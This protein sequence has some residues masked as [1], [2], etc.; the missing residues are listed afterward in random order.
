MPLSLGGSD[1]IVD[2]SSTFK[3]PN[4]VAGVGDSQSFQI[5]KS[6]GR[7]K[8]PRGKKNGGDKHGRVAASEKGKRKNRIFQ[9]NNFFYF[10]IFFIFFKLVTCYCSHI[11]IRSVAAIRLWQKEGV[12]CPLITC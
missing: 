2:G 10:F 9:N 6:T 3:A 1:D 12:F 8:R 7:N 4:L 11:T 5:F